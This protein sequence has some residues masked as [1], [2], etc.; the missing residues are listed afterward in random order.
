VA[1]LLV[2]IAVLLPLA[3]LSVLDDVRHSTPTNY[4]LDRTEATSDVRGELHLQVIGINEWESTATVRVSATQTCGRTCPWGDRYLFAADLDDG[5]A[6]ASSQVIELKSTSRDVVT[7]LRLPIAGDPIRYPFDSYRLAFGIEVAHVAE[8]GD[9]TKLT[10]EEAERYVDV[11]LQGRIPRTTMSAPQELEGELLSARE[12]DELVVSATLD[13]DRPLY[14]KALT[15]L[16]V[17]LVAAAAAFAV[18]M[19]PLDQ[20]VI[21]SGG[22]VLG[23]W[24]VRS[25]LL[26]SGVPGLTIVDITLVIVI[27]F[28]L[29][30][31]AVRTLWL[32]EEDSAYKV[33]RRGGNTP[34]ND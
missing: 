25:I 32:L 2:V 27:L 24:G 10:R 31:I 34:R 18:F 7:M 11:S 30:A 26:G 15:L 1:V 9:V 19:R 3:T 12:D 14:L 5:G 17:L 22:L 8:N 28:L 29:A 6:R 21:N 16:L 20:L 33:L 23:V 4:R 13:F